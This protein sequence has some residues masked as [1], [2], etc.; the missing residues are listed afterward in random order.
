MQLSHGSVDL[1]SPTKE[2]AN[3]GPD[4]LSVADTHMQVLLSNRPLTRQ[5]ANGKPAQGTFFEMRNQSKRTVLASDT[6][7][8][9]TFRTSQAM[10]NRPS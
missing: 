7:H 1:T 3:Q 9:E 5:T 6:G 10:S 2:Y 8:A 4:Y